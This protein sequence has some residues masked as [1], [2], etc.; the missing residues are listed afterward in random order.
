MEYGATVII[1]MFSFRQ[2]KVSIHDKIMIVYAASAYS[3]EW[4][5]VNYNIGYLVAL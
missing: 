5:V 3:Y 2:D 1:A 4:P